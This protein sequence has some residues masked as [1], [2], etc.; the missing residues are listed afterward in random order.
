MSRIIIFLLRKKLHLKKYEYFQFD[1]QN[2][3]AI[4]Y[5][6]ETSI[7]KNWYGAVTESNVGVNWL[8]NKNCKVRKYEREDV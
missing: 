8:L 1:N 4:Y 2:S 7:M 5:F 6:T 3:E